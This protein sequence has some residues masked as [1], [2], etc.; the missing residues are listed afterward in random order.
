MREVNRSQRVH[1]ETVRPNAAARA[2]AFTIWAYFLALSGFLP[3]IQAVVAEDIRYLALSIASGVGLLMLVDRKRQ[4]DAL[5][6]TQRVTISEPATQQPLIKP[7]VVTST[8]GHFMI[9]RGS[10]GLSQ[11]GWAGLGKAIAKNDGKLIRDIIPPN[12]FRNVT[13]AWPATLAELQRLELIDADQYLTPAGRDWFA[14][15]SPTLSD[16]FP[17]PGAPLAT[18]TTTKGDD[19]AQK[20]LNG[21]GANAH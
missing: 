6:L 7:E 20:Y 8:P 15:F 1:T 16:I 4:H 17:W 21:R 11:Q 5:S 18:T 10:I 12:T 19:A 14:K 3:L 13:A 2:G 9:R